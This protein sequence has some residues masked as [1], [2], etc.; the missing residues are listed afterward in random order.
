ML[1]KL[2]FGIAI[3]GVTIGAIAWLVKRDKKLREKAEQ[4][5]A[6]EALP[7]ELLME[8][9]VSIEKIGMQF[10]ATIGVYAT[11]IVIRLNAISEYVAAHSEEPIRITDLTGHVL[12]LA[13]KLLRSYAYCLV[14]YL[15]TDGIS[16]GIA[17][18]QSG[19]EYITMLLDRKL[20]AIHKQKNLDIA[21][22]LEAL[23]MQTVLLGR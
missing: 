20:V 11:Q 5:V 21:T 3:I 16:E 7:I 13:E 23:Q 15:D 1:L 22:D 10:P 18:A 14:H 9:I 6:R 4:P 8:H 19:L 12:P 17:S 2:I